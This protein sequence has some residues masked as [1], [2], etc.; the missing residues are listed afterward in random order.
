ML[1]AQV[2]M[3]RRATLQLLPAKRPLRLAREG[4][5]QSAL[6]PVPLA[7]LSMFVAARVAAAVV[8]P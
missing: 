8:V 4:V 5:R 3:A 2:T 1:W 6:V 7:V